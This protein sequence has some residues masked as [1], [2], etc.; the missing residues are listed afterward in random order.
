[1]IERIDVVDPQSALDKLVRARTLIDSFLEQAMRHPQPASSSS[2]TIAGRPSARPRSI[3]SLGLPK[4][5][6]TALH[7]AGI[8]SI[9]ALIQ[10][11][12]PTL[13]H[14]PG[15]GAR[16]VQSLQTAL[17]VYGLALPEVSRDEPHRQN[18]VAC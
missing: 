7:H 18:S 10:M 1:M 9:D 14:I 3:T 6:T 2:T 13:A 11:P 12:A 16:S 5:V 8:R 17:A 15:L 4:R